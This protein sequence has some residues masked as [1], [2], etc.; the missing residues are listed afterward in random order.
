MATLVEVVVAL[1]PRLSDYEADPRLTYAVRDMCD[2]GNM[3]ALEMR[4]LRRQPR[5]IMVNSTGKGGGVAEVLPSNVQV[6]RRMGFEA[7]WLVLTPDDDR[8]SRF[9][10]LTKRLHRLLHGYVAE[11]GSRDVITEQDVADYEAVTRAAAD[12]LVSQV[13]DGDIVVLHDPQ[14]IGMAPRLRA[15]NDNVVIVFRCHIGSDET[16]EASRAGWDFLRP[17]VQCADKSVF[18]ATEYIPSFLTTR[19][20]VIPPGIDPTDSKNRELSPPDVTNILANAGL[21]RPHHPLCMRSYRATVRRV[22]ADGTFGSAIDPDEFGFLFRPIITQVSRWDELKGWMPLFRAFVRLKRDQHLYLSSR[23]QKRSRERHACLLA[24]VRLVLA[25]PDPSSIQD[26]PDAGAV[27]RELCDEYAKLERDIQ[28]QIAILSLPMESRKE[29]ALIVNA[30]H[31]CSL[32]V[33]QNSIKEG[34]G[35]SCTEAMLKG[36][37]VISTRA[38]G[39]RQQINDGIEGRLVQD[40]NDVEELAQTMSDALKNLKQSEAQGVKARRRV[41]QDFTMFRV[42]IKWCELWRRLVDEK[43]IALSCADGYPSTATTTDDESMTERD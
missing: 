37:P 28:E 27:L 42:I 17:Y 4:Q 40:P 26:D 12:E 13:A 19:A 36:L 24:S 39:I 8:K 33:M 2:N 15:L 32:I 11:D 5:M 18:S 21:I 16:N 7:Y 35:L 23:R 29:N 9:F 30:L 31:R 20:V 6:L 14:T 25:G 3:L 22:H 10:N 1:G 38:C 43:R 41:F 34:W